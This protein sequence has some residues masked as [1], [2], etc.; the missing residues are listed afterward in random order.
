MAFRVKLAESSDWRKIVNAVSALVDEAVFNADADGLKLRAMD[1]SHVAMVDLEWKASGFEEYACDK[2]ISLGL[3]IREM[4]RLLRRTGS[5]ESLELSLDESGAKLLMK[6]TGKYA[7]TFS[8]ATLDI[9]GEEVPVV[10]VNFTVKA[11]VTGDCLSTTVED[12]GTVSENIRFEA[13]PEKLTMTASGDMGSF[14]VDL[15][16]SSEALLAL[17]VKE[18]AKATYS[19]SFLSQVVKA[20]T[21]S[22]ETATVEFANNM[23]LKLDFEL[24]QG[25]LE[26]YIAPYIE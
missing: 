21:A 26:Y 13:T 22:S 11:R 12:A 23:P 16:R 1:P 9:T 10:K 18:P 20:G 3:N 17:E 25:K 14:T 4:L 24:V 2:P 19:L 5:G 7:R 6:L 8:M 15:D